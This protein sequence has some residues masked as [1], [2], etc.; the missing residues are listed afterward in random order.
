VSRVG[1]RVKVD[2]LTYPAKPLGRQLWTVAKQY[3]VIDGVL[4][5]KGIRGL[6]SY[7]PL[8]SVEL[9]TALARISSETRENRL[10]PVDF[11]LEFGLLGHDKLVTEGR[12][13]G[14]SRI[15]RVQVRGGDPVE[16]I[17]AHSRAVG[18]C[19][20][21]MGL[22][23]EGDE[24]EIRDELEIIKPGPYAAEARIVN[25]P[26]AAHINRMLKE[27]VP[28]S[29]IVRRFI[30]TL[31]TENIVRVR[32][33]MSLDMFGTRIDSSLYFPA[34]I[35]AVY[36]QLADRLEGGGIRRCLGCKEF[37]VARDKRQQYCPAWPGSTRSR[38]SSRVNVRIFRA[39]QK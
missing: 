28:A 18:F 24:T 31:I 21:F 14:A 23:E 13:F 6:R 5:E 30:G 37:F 38:C 34:M 10:S 1:K 35:A 2:L 19:I 36:W 25:L 9:P 4:R 11:A 15:D 8:T 12:W 29:A 33:R 16:W 26:S 39:A 17:Q 27:N 20:R 3:E 22:L 32:R 7:Y